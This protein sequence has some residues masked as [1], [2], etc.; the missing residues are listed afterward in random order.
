MTLEICT[1]RWERESEHVRRCAWCG[2]EDDQT[3]PARVEVER[4]RARLSEAEDRCDE[5][6][7]HVVEIGDVLDAVDGETATEAAKRVMRKLEA[8]TNLI[9][10]TAARVAELKQQVAAL[11]D[12]LEANMKL[13]AERALSEPYRTACAALRAAGRKT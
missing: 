1:H 4:L 9:A 13:I 12:A 3:P 5:H 7:A 11:A 10:H 2:L 8:A 6:V